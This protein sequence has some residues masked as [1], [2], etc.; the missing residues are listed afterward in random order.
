MLHPQSQ[1][2][3]QKNYWRNTTWQAAFV[4]QKWAI[5]VLCWDPSSSLKEW[6]SHFGNGD[7]KWNI[8]ISTPPSSTRSHLPIHN[9]SLGSTL[10][11]S[12]CSAP[13]NFLYMLYNSICWYNIATIADPHVMDGNPEK[14]SVTQSL[15]FCVGWKKWVEKKSI[16]LQRHT[17]YDHASFILL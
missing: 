5:N 12:S 2:I 13:L 10:L 11:A 7:G 16:V 8:T 14:Q 3:V 9:F 1:Y 15:G 6:M 17:N 4:K